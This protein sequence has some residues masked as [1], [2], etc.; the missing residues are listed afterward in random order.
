MTTK[1]QVNE[2]ISALLDHMIDPQISVVGVGGAGCRVVSALYDNELQG[3]EIVAINSDKESLER[4][5]ADVKVLLDLDSHGVEEA[6][7]AAEAARESLT[8]SLRS[9]VTFL[10]AGMGGATGT[11]AAPTVA[12]IA[13]EN[14]G[15]VIAV[16]LM[17]F[18][19]EGRSHVA[20]KGLENLKEYADT[21]LAVDNDNLL[22]FEDLNFNEAMDVVNKMVSTLVKTVVEKLTSPV[23][24]SFTEE[25]QTSTEEVGASDGDTVMLEFGPPNGIEAESEE[26]EPD[27]GGPDPDYKPVGF[28]EKGFIGSL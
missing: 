23:N 13:T 5:R 14:G 6:E 3:L 2:A 9:D 11:G 17:P 25:V 27:Q 16:A 1:G 26:E 4:A 8:R 22:G 18:G 28:D 21:V 15:M 7:S 19:A 10:V 20:E 24:S 12:E